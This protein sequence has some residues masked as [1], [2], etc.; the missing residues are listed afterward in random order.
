MTVTKCNAHF[1][2]LKEAVLVNDKFQ[3]DVKNE[4]YE[5]PKE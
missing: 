5:N 1:F 3:T 4:T 2:Q